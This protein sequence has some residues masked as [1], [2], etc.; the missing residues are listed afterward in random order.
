MATG[1]SH[2]CLTEPISKQ[3]VSLNVHSRLGPRR[4]SEEVTTVIK[5]RRSAPSA[6]HALPS[7]VADEVET[8][9][10]AGIHSRLQKPLVSKPAPIGKRLGMSPVFQRLH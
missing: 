4:S 6:L 8:M 7:M 10:E 5:K 3:E 9:K 1:N 2:G